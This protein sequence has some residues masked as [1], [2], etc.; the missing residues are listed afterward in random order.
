[1]GTATRQGWSG[2]ERVEHGHHAG[3]LEPATGRLGRALERAGQPSAAQQVPVSDFRPPGA[4][5][6]GVPSLV[7]ADPCTSKAAR[8][9]NDRAARAVTPRSTRTS[10]DRLAWPWAA[11]RSTSA[12]VVTSS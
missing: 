2:G 1:M 4:G 9:L 3:D 11:S 12:S 10:C 6:E 5:H 7:M 8:L